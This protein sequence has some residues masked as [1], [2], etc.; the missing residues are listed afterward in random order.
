MDGSVLAFLKCMDG[1]I[2]PSYNAWTVPYWPS[3][4]AWTVPYCST[5]VP[6]LLWKK[7]NTKP[8]VNRMHYLYWWEVCQNC[9]KLHRCFFLPEAASQIEC[10]LPEPVSRIVCEWVEIYLTCSKLKRDICLTCFDLV[11][12]I[13]FSK[14]RKYFIKTGIIYRI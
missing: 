7:S 8:V 10:N 5:W 6:R 1:S 3:K 14:A 2:W 11:L 4:N 9:P 13:P 12:V